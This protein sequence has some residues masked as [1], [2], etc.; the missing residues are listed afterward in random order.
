MPLGPDAESNAGIIV[1]APHLFV[2]SESLAGIDQAIDL[3]NTTDLPARL[4]RHHRDAAT[5]FRRW[6][7]VWLDPSHRSWNIEAFVRQTRCPVLAIQGTEDEYATMAQIDAIARLAPDV[8]LLKLERC[9]HSP[10][11]D[12][13]DAVMAAMTRFVERVCAGA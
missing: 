12:Q 8:E 3:W 6:H 4:A 13:P 10:H 11:R 7:E 5:V 1:L 2:E 9:G